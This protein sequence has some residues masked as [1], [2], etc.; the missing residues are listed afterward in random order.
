MAM[1]WKSSKGYI[2][3]KQMEDSHLANA[4]STILRKIEDNSRLPK[5]LVEAAGLDKYD[6][7]PLQD[8]AL[9]FQTEWDRRLEERAVA[10]ANER[11]ATAY[12]HTRSYND[13]YEREANYM[14]PGYH[15]HNY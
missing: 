10:R 8:L 13:D 11:T 15:T 14:P 5:F 12:R 1:H 6:D 9:G 7:E 2:N 4:W 3:V